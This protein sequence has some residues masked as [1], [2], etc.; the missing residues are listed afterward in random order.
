MEKINFGTATELPGLSTHNT[1][2]S[3]EELKLKN[4]IVEIGNCL[5][6]KDTVDLL[7]IC[8]QDF[9]Y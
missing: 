2:S 7:T 5:L 4:L 1:A 3:L 9:N 6:F 8:I